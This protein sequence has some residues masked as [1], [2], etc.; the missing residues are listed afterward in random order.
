MTQTEIAMRR[1]LATFRVEAG[2]RV[3]VLSQGQ[4]QGA[5]EL[6]FREGI[7]FVAYDQV[8]LGPGDLIWNGK[9]WADRRTIDG[10]VLATDGRN[11]K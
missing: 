4:G 11:K 7:D 1:R 9:R 6:G 5:T 8:P 3:P 10:E 2:M